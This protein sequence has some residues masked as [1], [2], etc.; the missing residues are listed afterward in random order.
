MY[1]SR[2]LP[3]AC[4]TRLRDNEKP[5]WAKHLQQPHTIMAND[6]RLANQVYALLACELTLV[7]AT[8]GLL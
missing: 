3:N 1:L 2:R 4:V 5:V 7:Q 8:R 6:P